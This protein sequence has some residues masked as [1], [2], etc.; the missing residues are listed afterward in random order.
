MLFMSRR[1][2]ITAF[3]LSPLA[4]ALYV[5]ALIVFEK[6]L[7]NQLPDI[8]GLASMVLFFAIIGY[9]AEGVMGI[10]L[11]FLFRRINRLTL[12]WFLLGGFV[13]GTV[14]SVIVSIFL[15]AADDPLSFALLYCIAPAIISTTVFW[16]IGWS[17]DNKALQ[18][19]A[20]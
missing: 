18:L 5:V 3:L 17:A 7:W 15:G 19:T 8:L 4:S 1:R 6:R 2:I 20:R 9:V 11:L 12:P 10:P 14:I 16:F 13:I